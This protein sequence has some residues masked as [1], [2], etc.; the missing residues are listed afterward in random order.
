MLFEGIGI[1]VNQL[2]IDRQI[3]NSNSLPQGNLMEIMYI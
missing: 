2:L 3:F 1:Q